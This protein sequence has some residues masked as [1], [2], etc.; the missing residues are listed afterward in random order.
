V[1]VGARILAMED[2]SSQTASIRA[3]LTG[4]GHDVRSC[5]DPRRFAAEVA[6]FQPDLV[7]MDVVQP[8]SSGFD[9]AR[10]MLSKP[11][12]RRPPVVFVTTE[13]EIS[14]RLEAAMVGGDDCLVKPVQPAFLLSTVAERLER[15]TRVQLLLEYDAQTYLLTRRAFLDRAHDAVERKSHDPRR[16][17]CWAVIAL[18]AMP[19]I[20][21]L[22]GP[23]A[24]DDVLSRTATLLRR[25]L[26]PGES[27]GR[28]QGAAFT[29]LLDDLRP[30]QA[31][32][33]IELLRRQLALIEF[34]SG[35]GRFR[36]T[37]SGGVA[38][39][40][41]GMTVGTWAEAADGALEAAKS[42]G[43]NRIEIAR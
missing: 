15:A 21:S 7:L 39:L 20:N 37:L 42:A 4:A 1:R 36:V 31:L 3:V 14:S 23:V 40:A 33:R 5:G 13:S 12:G 8:G 24:G 35:A 25:S 38:E 17:T 30:K 32:A 11:G 18:D 22:H 29:L 27:A 19:S 10:S 16:R 6:E 26:V 2:D 9:L 28:Y 41:P 34:R 43:G